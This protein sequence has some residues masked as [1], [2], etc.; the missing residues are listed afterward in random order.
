MKAVGFIVKFRPASSA[1]SLCQTKVDNKYSLTP[2]GQFK[3]KTISINDGTNI[4]K[5]QYCC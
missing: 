1:L 2:S 5:Q 4:V 3:K